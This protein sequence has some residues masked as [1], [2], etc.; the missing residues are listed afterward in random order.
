MLESGHLYCVNQNEHDLWFW[1]LFVP[2]VG[3]LIEQV[4][5][6]HTETHVVEQEDI[7]QENRDVASYDFSGHID[8]GFLALGED[9][10]F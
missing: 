5:S 6:D 2:N 7:Q 10:K 1:N 3:R 9:S 4:D 8:G